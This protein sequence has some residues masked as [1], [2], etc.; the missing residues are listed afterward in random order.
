LKIDIRALA[1]A[2]AA[3]AGAS[4]VQALTINQTSWTAAGCV[5][6]AG[7]AGLASCTIG[8]GR[9]GAT[10]TATSIG[11]TG[12]L[13]DQSEFRDTSNNDA[14]GLGVNSTGVT[15]D[16]N[17]QNNPELQGPRTANPTFQGEQIEIAFGLAPESPFEHFLDTIVLRHFYN[18]IAFP[19]N[20]NGVGGDPQE[21]AFIEGFD[22]NGSVGKLKLE[23]INYSGGL[24]VGFTATGASFE[25]ITRT[26]FT[27]QPTGNRNLGE[28]TISG[29]FKGQGVTRVV[30]S[31]GT[32]TTAGCDTHDYS[33]GSISTT[34]V[35]LPLPLAFALTA[36]G[37]A[38]L[39]R[40]RRA[41]A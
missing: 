17:G 7:T 3:A 16:G 9:D 21:I 20:Q 12:G 39:C 19:P 10:L 33:I 35:P 13:F 41:A 31:A 28:F 27:G 5:T 26:T 24:G 1:L 2:A 37:G 25:S 30:F 6:A 18:P 15:S 40:R 32:C 22:A 34:P 8:S 38:A 4:S 11:N 14:V 36:I 29:L 23:N